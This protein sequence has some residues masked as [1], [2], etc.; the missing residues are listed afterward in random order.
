MV[1]YDVIVDVSYIWIIFR[2]VSRECDGRIIGCYLW[3]VFFLMFGLL[4][5]IWGMIVVFFKDIVELLVELLMK[6]D[7]LFIYWVV[8]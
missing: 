2:L 6:D 8:S 1:I 5:Y 7:G 4:K 3:L